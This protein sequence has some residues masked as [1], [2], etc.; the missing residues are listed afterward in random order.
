MKL[1][2]RERRDRLERLEKLCREAGIPCTIQRRALLESN[3][4]STMA[5]LPRQLV[6]RIGPFDEALSHAE[7]WDFW[8]RAV[9]AGAVVVPQPRPLAL[10]RRHGVGLS[11]DVAAMDRGVRQVLAKMAARPDLTPAERAYV[12]R[13]LDGPTPATCVL[14]GERALLERRYD[15]AARALSTAADLVPHERALARKAQLLALAPA[16]TGPVLRAR[17]RRRRTLLAVEDTALR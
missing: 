7:D 17:L 6:E 5:L 13:R 16:V 10:Y 3:F 11:A 8:L 12:R 4:V 14:Q 9:F 1:G 15:D 2:A